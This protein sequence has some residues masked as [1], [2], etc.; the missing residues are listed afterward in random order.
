MTRQAAAVALVKNAGSGDRLA[1]DTTQIGSEH[2]VGELVLM[3]HHVAADG[4]HGQ[5]G[6]IGSVAAAES[7]AEGTR[8]IQHSLNFGP[9]DDG[10]S[11]AGGFSVP[12]GEGL[13]AGEPTVA[14]NRFTNSRTRC[15]GA[16]EGR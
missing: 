13:A 8:S 15:A 2:V 16:V 3:F 14:I 12:L 6:V 1:P 11:S 9:R 4:L 7:L 5:I 10:R